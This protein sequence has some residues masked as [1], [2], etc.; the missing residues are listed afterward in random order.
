[1]RLIGLAVVLAVSIAL[2]SV[3]AS[4]QTARTPRIGFLGAGNAVPVPSQLEAF[5]EGLRELGWIESQAL[6]IE[7]R[8]I[9]GSPQRVPALAAD[10]VRLNVAVSVA[11]GSQAIRAPKEGAARIP[12]CVD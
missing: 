7:Y 5:R 1:M 3:G 8:W 4:A 9:E 12:I 11:P 6:T 10:L 2:A